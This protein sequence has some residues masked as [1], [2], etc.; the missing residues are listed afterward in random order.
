MLKSTVIEPC[1]QTSWPQGHSDSHTRRHWKVIRI[2]QNLNIYLYYLNNLNDETITYILTPHQP[3]H[4]AWW[5]GQKDSSG[6]SCRLIWR[7]SLMSHGQQLMW[8]QQVWQYQIPSSSRPSTKHYGI[9]VPGL[10]LRQE[11]QNFLNLTWGALDLILRTFY[12][13]N[14]QDRI[15]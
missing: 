13:Q 9:Q 12:D 4:K 5:W 10:D 14:F 8:Q 1:C 3:M 6:A 15:K 7:L 2:E 11:N